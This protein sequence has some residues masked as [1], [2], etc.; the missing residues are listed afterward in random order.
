MSSPAKKFKVEMNAKQLYMTGCVVLHR[1]INVV[2]VEGGKQM[3][4]C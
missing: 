1:D 4:L 3:S 2:V